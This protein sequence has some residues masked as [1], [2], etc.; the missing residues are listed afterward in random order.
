[1]IGKNF[2]SETLKNEQPIT[3]TDEQR[4][5]ITTVG[6]NLCVAAGAGSG[7]TTVLVERYLFLLEKAGME[8]K[9]I[10]AITFTEKAAN[11]MK[12]KIRSKMRERMNS[13][14]D[15]RERETWERRYREIGSAPI[16][17]IHGFCTR[18]LREK[19]VEAGIDPHFATLDDIETVLL[20]H[21]TVADFVNERL[22]EGS[23]DIILLLTAY[24]LGKT[25]ELLTELLRQREAVAS[26][27]RFYLERSDG[28][29]LA[30]LREQMED[31]LRV[32]AAQLEGVAASDSED[33]VEKI[34]R[35]VLTH[36]S[37]DLTRA[38]LESL[39]ILIKL[40]GGSKKKWDEEDL[41]RAKMLLRS[42]LDQVR[43]LLPLHD[44]NRIRRDLALLRSL[45]Q[46]FGPLCD[47]YREEKA[48]QGLLDF[49]DLLI[50][51]R[52]LLRDHAVV[53]QAYRKEI[54]TL[55]IDELQDT[56]PLQMEIVEGIC[57]EEPGRIFGVGDAKQSIYRFRGADVSVFQR[58]RQRV[59]KEDS[60]GVVPLNK[61][62][63][64]QEEVLHFINYLFSRIL[65]EVGTKEEVSFD[66]LEPHKESL[67]NSHFV[68]CCFIPKETD[69]LDTRSREAVWIAD[70][71]AAMVEGREERIL[72]EEGK[73][74]P[75]E[76]GDIALLFRAMTDVKL[77]EG[78]LRRRGIPYTVIS[79]G[80]FFDKQEV[81][82]VLNMLRV[83]LYPDDEEA[84]T[85]ILRSPIAGVRDDT[86]YFMTRGHSLSQGLAQAEE[87]EV[88]DE[89]ER[90]ILLHVRQMIER[91]RQ[92][93]DRVRIPELIGRFLDASSYPAL[94]LADPVHGTQRYANLK[95]LM[96]LARD[97]SARPFFSLSDFIDYMN[98]LKE[99]EAREAESSIDE[100]SSDTVRIMTIHKAKGLEFP[101]VFL[102]D[103]GR[104]SGGKNGPLLVD[105]ELGIGIRVPN[106][107][108]GLENCSL[109][110]PI[111]EW[112]KIKDL[113]E[114]KRLFYVACTRA[115]DFLLLSG[116]IDFPK[117]AKSNAT[118]PLAWLKEALD[119]REDNY[120][121]DLPYGDRKIKVSPEP[122]SP[123]RGA[124]DGKT[125][126]DL[127]PSILRG[128]LPPV[129]TEE[130]VPSFIEQAGH[131]PEILPPHRFTV[132]QLLDYKH[133][134]RGY[135]LSIIQGISEPS[136]EEE[137][138][139][140][141]GGREL[142]SLVH[143]MLQRWDMA[144]YSME[145]TVE[146]E[147]QRSGLTERER[148]ELHPKTMRLVQSFA[149]MD[150]A[151]EI[152][153]ASEVRTEVP[154]FLK[155]DRFQVEGVIDKLYRNR[156]GRLTIIDYK[157]DRVSAGEVPEKA[158]KYRF[159]LALYALAAARLFGEPVE[160]LLLFLHPGIVH[161]L[162]NDPDKTEKEVRSMIRELQALTEFPRNR[163]LCPRCGYYS[164]FCPGSS[165]PSARPGKKRS[166]F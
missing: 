74:R 157:T 151:A 3:F 156:E 35:D 134:P 56:D 165:T 142:G 160:T 104:K 54:K 130:S 14:T 123:H 166:H 15:L 65:P 6:K 33:L 68:E 119:I 78:E 150:I 1:M 79:G 41:D 96:D 89:S 73:A 57:G 92:V 103:L 159:Q 131:T 161:P 82:D 114:E 48:S 24:G 53:R 115:K 67:P 62:F 16:H 88:I 40:R 63:R 47:R 2:M 86:L 58:F 64:S 49:D 154:F 75:V 152:R 52:D 7:K 44:E 37:G 153:D 50:F 46:E 18:I 10:V 66:R 31:Q 51:S 87:I 32:T 72:V 70:R 98:E 71:I 55:L 102:P 94:L 93:R 101:V 8:T 4:R 116:M 42:V 140:P 22:N 158:D 141:S 23:D 132:S 61:N 162:K 122:P 111:V 29:I 28:E 38:V 43:N 112:N 139:I 155:V 127:Y 39:C 9:E 59:N 163:E 128:K 109:R 34:R 108:G 146:R 120:T 148:R 30:P 118:F 5:A 110:T 117:S 20:I 91:L 133:C 143:G 12:E 36:L 95:K 45:L 121:E 129:P 85:G 60:E 84:L 113:N 137:R 21:K 105:T 17:T 145:E 106:D 124:V 25:R 27:Q 136:R 81:L 99:K 80:G 19:A 83:L 126:I 135:E 149:D 144:P 69:V 11:Q 164:H 107:Q 125:W 100:E 13:A 138:Y 26:W 76:Y 77:Y 147:L 90:A 97:F